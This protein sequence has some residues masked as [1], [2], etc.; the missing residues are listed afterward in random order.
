MI[1][2]VPRPQFKAI[3]V[4]PLERFTFREVRAAFFQYCDRSKNTIS[5]TQYSD[6]TIHK[7]S[8]A[9]KYEIDWGPRRSSSSFLLPATTHTLLSPS[10]NPS[11]IMFSSSTYVAHIHFPILDCL[12]VVVSH[13]VPVQQEGFEIYD[14]V[15][16]Y[17]DS[18][19]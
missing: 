19:R 14:G 7:H 17:L 18:R 12:T 2:S 5:R 15:V 8:T 3:N 16:G 9:I 4:R 6:T 10:P 1:V 11:S 13:A